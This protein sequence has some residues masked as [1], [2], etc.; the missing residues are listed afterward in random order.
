MTKK[1]NLV[2]RMDDELYEQAQD[3]AEENH[4]SVSGMVRALLRFWTNREDPRPPLDEMT[5]ESKPENYRNK[6]RRR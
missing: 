1:R 3:Y 6:K 4:L 2:V 5:E